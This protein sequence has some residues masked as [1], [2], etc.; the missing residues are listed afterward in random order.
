VRDAVEACDWV[1]V[2]GVVSVAEAVRVM[3]T[4]WESL[5][6]CVVDGVRGECDWVFGDR[7]AVLGRVGDVVV[8]CVETGE[9]VGVAGDGVR[10]A[11]VSVEVSV[12]GSV[13]VGTKVGV[14]V[15]GC[16]VFSLTPSRPN[17]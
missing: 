11:W 5:D 17:L 3:R 2:R 9:D 6:V 4:E 1:L 15:W 16:S 10:V 12:V 14:I 7:D 8:V 13:S